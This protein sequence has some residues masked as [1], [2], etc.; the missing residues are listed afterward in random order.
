M[1]GSAIWTRV[2]GMNKVVREGMK[3]CRILDIFSVLCSSCPSP[4]MQGHYKA[5]TGA[6]PA[7]C[8]ENWSCWCRGP[9]LGAASRRLHLKVLQ[10]WMGRV[11]DWDQS[12]SRDI[13]P[14]KLCLCAWQFIYPLV[15]PPS[16][17]FA[18]KSACR[19]ISSSY[20]TKKQIMI[21]L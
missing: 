13:R 3:R 21:I 16:H 12:M 10:S 2:G 15:K 14:D 19:L 20:C 18:G 5:I 4:A 7:L 17:V 8:T 9:G 6:A 11:T 1:N